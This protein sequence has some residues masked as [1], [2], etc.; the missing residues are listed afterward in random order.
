MSKARRVNF[1]NG[2]EVKVRATYFDNA[3]D[4]A[5]GAKRWSEIT[6]KD[7]WASAFCYGQIVKKSTRSKWNIKFPDGPADVDASAMSLVH[8][9]QVDAHA[10]VRKTVKTSIEGEVEDL[11]SDSEEEEINL[12]NIPEGAIPQLL[13]T[14]EWS[15]GEDCPAE[16]QRAKFVTELYSKPQFSEH[17]HGSRTSPTLMDLWF[18]WTDRDFMLET[19]DVINDNGRTKY[20]EQWNTLTLGTY[21][22]WLGLWH[23]MLADPL[24]GSR[25]AYWSNS[26][27]YE[28]FTKE[29]ASFDTVMGIKDFEMIYSVYA[30]PMGDSGDTHKEVRKGILSFNKRAAAIFIPGFIVVVDESM[31]EWEGM[32]MPGHAFVARKPKPL[33]MECKTACCGQS[34]IIIRL[35]VQEGA[36]NMAYKD[37]NVEWGSQRDPAKSIGCVLRLTLPWHNTGRI[38]IADS[39]FGSVRCAIALLHYGLFCVMNVKTA[40][41]FYPKEALRVEISKEK[42]DYGKTAKITFKD[43]QPFF[44][45]KDFTIGVGVQ[46][47]KKPLFAVYTAE[48]MLPG[49]PRY[50]TYYEKDAEGI[51]TKQTATYSTTKVHGLY[52]EYFNRIDHHNKLR[53]QFL[54]FANIWD[55]KFWSHRVIGELWGTILTNVFFTAKNMYPDVYSDLVPQM[56]KDKIAFA[57]IKNPLLAL[58]AVARPRS[59]LKPTVC[60]LMQMPY[61]KSS[62][63]PI[64]KLKDTSCRYCRHNTSWFCRVCST[65]KNYFGVCN[66]N[67][68]GCMVKHLAGEPIHPTKKFRWGRTI[69]RAKAATE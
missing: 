69:M 45:T 44:K 43:K 20:G 9:R 52:R 55:T 31:W 59:A 17:P 10:K 36:V 2:D 62:T 3:K 65:E 34:K 21:L 56:F 51:E 5:A 8:P 61:R 15:E 22:A 33:G 60:S 16:D 24:P 42:R 41:K 6:F 57:L 11:Q 63:G 12:K 7:Q 54:S 23:Q 26:K 47:E 40:H 48:T 67:T 50:L 19:V 29:R 4:V 68:R 46:R 66:V 37:Y 18:L 38:I 30:I 28:C 58:E 64:K 32:F 25:R 35:D 53:Q 13:G 39:W 14:V 49:N 27:E 1:Q